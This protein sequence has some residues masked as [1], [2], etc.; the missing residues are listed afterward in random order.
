MDYRFFTY[1]SK[2]VVKNPIVKNG[3]ELEGRT[4]FIVSK[5]R[6][7]NGMVKVLISELETVI[8]FHY[9]DLMIMK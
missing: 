3:I 8:V 9:T 1:G 5:N 6:K 7:T 2:V 4:G